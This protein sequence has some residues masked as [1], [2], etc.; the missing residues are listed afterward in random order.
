MTRSVCIVTDISGFKSQTDSFDEPEDLI[1]HPSLLVEW[2]LHNSFTDLPRIFGWIVEL[3][4]YDT[5]AYRTL[6]A[7]QYF[8]PASERLC[9]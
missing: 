3:S 4:A 7:R 9:A 5:V 6:S 2:V 8:W 1:L